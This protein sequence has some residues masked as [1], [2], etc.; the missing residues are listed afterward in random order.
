MKQYAF[1]FVACYALFCSAYASHNDFPYQRESMKRDFNNQNFCTNAPYENY[2]K[3]CILH[4]K[5]PIST[6]PLQSFSFQRKSLKR[7]LDGNQL[8]MIDA[9]TPPFKQYFQGT[10]N[11]YHNTIFDWVCTDIVPYDPSVQYQKNYCKID[12][13]NIK[14]SEELQ[15]LMMNCMKSNQQ[16]YSFFEQE[17]QKFPTKDNENDE[18]HANETQL[19]LTDKYSGMDIE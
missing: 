2:K 15:Q 10:E 12:D 16:I 1:T 14:Y 11:P 4:E 17:E 18:T 13:F 3:P 6:M 8:S 19:L 7:D 5:Q 9:N